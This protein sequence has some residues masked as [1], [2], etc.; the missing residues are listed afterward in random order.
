[1]TCLCRHRGEAAEYIQPF[2]NPTLE[3]GGWSTRRSGRFA[4]GKDPMYSNRK[5]GGPWRQSGLHG[6]SRPI[7]IRSPDRPA[8]SKSLYRLHYPGRCVL[9]VCGYRN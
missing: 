1:M 5:L 7:G 8:L 2:R 6:K 3:G 9:V 4:P